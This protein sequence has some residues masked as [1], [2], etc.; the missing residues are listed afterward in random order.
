MPYPQ[1]LAANA[2]GG[3]AWSSV[4][5]IVAYKVG[6]NADKIFGQLSVWALVAIAAVVVTAYAIYKVRRRSIPAA[7]GPAEPES[8]LEPS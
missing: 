4:I 1:F 5:G 8:E 7:L 6:D 3:I 2:A